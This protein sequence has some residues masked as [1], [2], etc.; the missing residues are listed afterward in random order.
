MSAGVPVEAV[1]ERVAT[2]W[3]ATAQRLHRASRAVHH[4]AGQANDPAS[5]VSKAL[6]D[7]DAAVERIQAAAKE[8]DVII[9]TTGTTSSGKSTIANL[10]VGGPLLPKAVQEMSAGV[11][12]IVHDDV[13]RQLTVEAT[14]GATWE[15]GTWHDI[16]FEAARSRLELT[17]EAY[18]REGSQPGGCE[19]VE[20]PR[21]LVTWPTRIGA[22]RVAFGLPATARVT[23]VDL[24]GLKFVNDEANA[25]VVREQAR[26]AL[27]LVAYNSFEVDPRKQEALLGEV[28]DQVKALRGS[29][30]RM[31]F[32][33]NRIDAFLT[34]RDPVASER[35]FASRM[36]AQIRKGLGDALPEF[37]DVISRISPVCLS[38]EPGLYAIVAESAPDE[39]V[40]VLRRLKRDY[41]G[42]FSDDE[43]EQLPSSPATWSEPQRRWFIEEA[44][45]RSRLVQFEATLREHVAVNLPELILPVLIEAA[46]R[47]ARRVLAE[48][49]AMCL[50]YSARATADVAAAQDRLEEVHQRLRRLKEECLKYLDPLR[51]VEAGDGDLVEKL[52]VAVPKVESLL[53]V[54]RQ[55]GNPARGPGVLAGLC[56]ALPDAV[57][58][59]LQRLNAAV[60]QMMQGDDTQDPVL[61]GLP[62][63]GD[64]VSATR[65]LRAG[66]YSAAWRDG[67]AFEGAQAT[68]VESGLSRLAVALASV[69]TE[70]VGRESRIQAD[71][72]KG[73]LQ[74]C[75]AVVVERLESQAAGSADEFRNLRGVFRG[76]FDLLPPRLPRVQFSPQVRHWERV[77]H[78]HVPETY[79]VQEG[80]WWTLGIFKRRVQKTR[81]VL[82]TTRTNVLE[83]AKLGDLLEGFARSGSLA[84]L[85]QVFAA[86]LVDGVHSFDV[87]LGRRLDEGVKVYRDVLLRRLEQVERAA[88]VQISAMDAQ[89]EEVAALIDEVQDSGNWRRDR[90]G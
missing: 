29:P 32:V 89:R 63:A 27:C 18:R 23:L 76:S 80:I 26:R 9:A 74:A 77:E 61:D 86:W 52:L 83:V 21:F 64:L 90:H 1:L 67:G 39:S 71:R 15:A 79:Y 88:D 48:A 54:S 49:E 28:V 34:D 25:S 73:G 24:P 62:G 75:A 6:A 7:L 50:A 72:M 35:H 57:Q 2:R 44:K 3:R 37:S 65:A 16:T 14:V 87:A 47:A 56:N 58:V 78:Q 12:T 5:S 59:P 10:L 4:A 13:K 81:M 85:E 82:H 84:A 68:A 51:E 69:A 43:I 40:T 66:P 45:R 55:P 33:L 17:M 38:S 20:P 53:G 70:L 36:T 22:E 46:D 11:V 30:A 31:L 41:Q 60:M 8:P 42:L 19:S